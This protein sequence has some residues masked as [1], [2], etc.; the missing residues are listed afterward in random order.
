MKAS[1]KYCGRIHDKKYICSNRPKQTKYTDINKFR[2]TKQWRVKREEIRE[3]DKQL[4]QVCIRKLYNTEQQ[5]TYNDLSV[6]H[7]IPIES[8][9]TKRLDNDNL[10]TLCRYHHELA[11]SKDI[12]IRVILEIIKEQNAQQDT[13]LPL[14]SV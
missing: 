7:A 11:E 9:Y 12:P 14:L 1:C 5:Y 3:R 13:P 4:C 2:S 6:H 10:L 8:D